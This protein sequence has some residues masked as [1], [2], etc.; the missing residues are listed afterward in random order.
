MEPSDDEMLQQ[1]KRANRKPIYI[2]LGL[3]AIGIVG[4]GLFVLSNFSGAKSSLESQGYTDVHVK[5]TGPITFAFDAKRGTSSC[6]GTIT[7]MPGSSSTQELCFDTTPSPSAAPKAVPLTN[8]QQVEATLKTNFGKRGFDGFVCPDIADTDATAVCTA[9]AKSNGASLAVT[10]TVTKHDADGTWGAWEMKPA[11]PV[12]LGSDL[13]TDLSPDITSAV[14]KRYAKATVELDC[15]TGP[16]VFTD[17]KAKCKAT[18]RNPDKTIDLL[19]T[20]QDTSTN[21]SLKEL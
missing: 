11:Q 13:V 1:M 6:S 12:E 17:N 19:L 4:S 21:W 9:T 8:R 3:V 15:G 5:L 18:L 16:V 20:R 7:R 10:A 2:V 14:L